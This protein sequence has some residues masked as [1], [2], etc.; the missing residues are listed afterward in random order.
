MDSRFQ[1]YLPKILEFGN[2]GSSG[3]QGSSLILSLLCVMLRLKKIRMN[4]SMYYIY[5]W[6]CIKVM[7]SKLAE[8]NP[9][10]Q[11]NIEELSKLQPP[12]EQPPN[13][14]TG[15]SKQPPSDATRA[16]NSSP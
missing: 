6:P 8:K 2:S 7:I 5:A 15:T 12:S 9:E 10:L 16:S 4:G 13:D 14:A 11:I 1:W 3:H